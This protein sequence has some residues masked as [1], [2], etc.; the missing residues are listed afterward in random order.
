MR[1]T[2]YAFGRLVYPTHVSGSTLRLRPDSGLAVTLTEVEE[3]R[4]SDAALETTL[5]MREVGATPDPSPPPPDRVLE[6]AVAALGA[7]VGTWLD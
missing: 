2:V 1:R 6:R 7:R 4:W 5:R 3:R